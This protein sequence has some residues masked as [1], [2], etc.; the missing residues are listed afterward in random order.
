MYFSYGIYYMIMKSIETNI[1]IHQ[2][3]SDLKIFIFWHNQLE[4]PGSIMMRWIIENSNRHL[5]KNLKILLPCENFCVACSQ[6]KL[7]IK[8]SPLK[9]VIKSLSFP[10]RIQRDICG[11][12]HPPYESFRYF[13]ILIGISSKWH[14]CLLSS[15]NVSF[16]RLTTQII[17]Q[18]V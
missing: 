5:L 3:C 7:I 1:V 11:P 10:K 17:K 4:R 18:R 13:I 6:S 2:K 8:P 14:V 9:V 12:I 15:W 16:I